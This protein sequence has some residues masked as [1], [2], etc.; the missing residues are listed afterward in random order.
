MEQ[1]LAAYPKSNWA[2][3]AMY[4]IGRIYQGE[5][6]YHDAASW[7]LHGYTSYPGS[8]F[9][10]ESLWRAGW[11]LYLNAEYTEASQQFLLVLQRFPEGSYLDDARYWL[12]RTYERR[13]QTAEAIAAYQQIL[14]T[15]PETYYGLRA[16]ERLRALHA[17]E[18]Q[19]APVYGTTPDIAQ[20]LLELQQILPADEY[21]LIRPHLAKIFELQQVDL[22]RHAASEADW[23][24]GLIGNGADL[25][26]TKN[27]RDRQLLLR[28]YNSR[29]YAIAGPYLKTIQWASALE[30]ILK[31]ED[32]HQYSYRLETFP[33]RLDTIKYPLGYW[34]LISAYAPS[35]NLDPFLVAAI[36]RQESAYDPDAQ[37][38][39]DAR[40]LMQ[41]LPDTGKRLAGQLQFQ[42]FHAERLYEPE[43]NIMLGTAYMAQMIEK[44]SGNLKTSAIE[45]PAIT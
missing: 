23:L 17:P 2:D 40:G 44:F 10:E 29:I 6:A 9:A 35:N 7:Y 11:C 8:S 41:V 1:V 14:Q 5:K 42:N 25:F 21:N 16:T 20:V 28:Y 13:Q 37:S 19:P 32:N 4:V 34:E 38:H 27:T 24:V 18:P 22:R 30:S 26:D 36:I 15:S 39:A 33:Y 45:R 3:N 31:D 12:G 43:L